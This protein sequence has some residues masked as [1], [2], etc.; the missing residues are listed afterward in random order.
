M[1]KATDKPQREGWSIGLFGEVSDLKLMGDGRAA[2]TLLW[3]GGSK[4]TYV[5]REVYDTIKDGDMVGMRFRLSTF[6]D[7]IKPVDGRVVHVNGADVDFDLVYDR[8]AAAYKAK[9]EQEAARKQTA[10]AR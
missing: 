10:G 7:N 9:M 1:A 8:D 3:R 2:M 5:P 6:S 4:F